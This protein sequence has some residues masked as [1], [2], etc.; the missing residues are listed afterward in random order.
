M[1]TETSIIEIL[2][3]A[4]DNITVME[5]LISYEMQTV[6]KLVNC[7]HPQ[8]HWVMI[9]EISGGCPVDVHWCSFCGAFQDANGW[10]PPEMVR[11]LAKIN[12][13]ANERIGDDEG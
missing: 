10:I 13:A 4:K 1:K 8:T 6:E 5:R 9:S 11:T 3:T 2:T 7:E 12:E